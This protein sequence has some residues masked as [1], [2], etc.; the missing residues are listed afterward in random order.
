LNKE[1]LFQYADDQFKNSAKPEE[2]EKIFNWFAKLGKFKK[3]K[4][5]K[6]KLTYNN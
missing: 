5:S 2:Y 3:Y 6:D 1:T 4:E